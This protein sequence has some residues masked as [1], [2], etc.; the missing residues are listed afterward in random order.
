MEKPPM[1][2]LGV[3]SPVNMR[4]TIIPMP[5]TS[6]V[7]RSVTRRMIA[8]SRMSETMRMSGVTGPPWYIIVQRIMIVLSIHENVKGELARRESA[9]LRILLLTCVK[10]WSNW[11]IGPTNDRECRE[12]LVFTCLSR[13]GPGCGG[14][15]P[16]D[17][18]LRVVPHNP[19][20]LFSHPRSYSYGR[21]TNQSKIYLSGYR[22]SDTGHDRTW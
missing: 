7:N 11:G 5:V 21:Q 8:A 22:T 20:M 13:A 19:D 1:A 15:G 14:A 9:F 4:T 12:V 18:S 2:S 16:E 6:T 10:E 17:A 3:S